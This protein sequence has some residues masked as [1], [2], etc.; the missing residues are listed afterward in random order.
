MPPPTLAAT[1][2]LKVIATLPP[3]G[4]LKVPQV[5]AVAPTAGLLIAVR[6]APPASTGVVFEAKVK[7]VG[8]TS[9]ISTPVA[10]LLPELL[11]VM[12]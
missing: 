3:A 4:M 6:V 7:P 5:G 1:L 11:T 9:L 2:A 10:V 8:N 12:V